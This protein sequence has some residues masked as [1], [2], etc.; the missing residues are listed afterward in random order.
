[1]QRIVSGELRI[2]IN[3][4]IK[5]QRAVPVGQNDDLRFGR[6][7]LSKCTTDDVFY[8]S[9]C[10]REAAC[11]DVIRSANIDQENIFG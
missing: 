11:G 9:V 2:I 7:P 4:E 1:M 10:V 6:V 3:A 5:L 8:A